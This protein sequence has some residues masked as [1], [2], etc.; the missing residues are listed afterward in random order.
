VL[1]IPA[2]D[3]VVRLLPPLNMSTEDLDEAVWRLD[4][5]AAALERQ[6]DANG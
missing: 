4:R 2:S 3:N 6:L 1:V 5:A